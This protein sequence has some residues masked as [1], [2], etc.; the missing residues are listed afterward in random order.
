M[1]GRQSAADGALFFLSFLAFLL[2]LLWPPFLAVADVEVPRLEH[3]ESVFV[4]VC[5]Q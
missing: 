1:A 4:C 5:Y 3:D 2:A